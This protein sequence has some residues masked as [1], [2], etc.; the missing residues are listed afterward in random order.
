MK[1]K[2]NFVIT[3]VIRAV[4]ILFVPYLIYIKDYLFAFGA[5]LAVLLS[6]APAIIKRN[7][8]I[9]MPWPLEFL[10]VLALCLH[11]VGVNFKLFDIPFWSNFMHFSGSAVIALL[12]FIGVYTLNFTKRIKLNLFMIGFFTLVFAIAIGALWEI[13]EF[14]CDAYLGTITQRGG[15]ADTIWDLIFDVIAGAVVAIA[16]I[17]YVKYAPKRAN[18]IVED[19]L[20]ER[21]RKTKKEV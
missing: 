19:M 12:A 10:I 7:Y 11:I 1:H 4:L 2:L 18:G 5:F 3:Q 16:G 21:N 6:L 15:L 17:L 13:G 8:R 9:I 14:F 20:K